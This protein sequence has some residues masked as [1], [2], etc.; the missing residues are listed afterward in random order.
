MVFI[1]NTVLHNDGC[2]IIIDCSTECSHVVF[3]SS[4]GYSECF[5]TAYENSS[6][7]RTAVVSDVGV[8]DVK[9]ATGEYCCIDQ[10]AG[11]AVTYDNVLN[12]I[13]NFNIV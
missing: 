3:K 6:T 13:C 1:E 2:P 10:V 12:I 9:A 7:I 5:I 11:I 4:A 8:S